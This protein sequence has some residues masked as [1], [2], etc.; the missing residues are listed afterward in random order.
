M[1][2]YHSLLLTVLLYL[3]YTVHAAVTGKNETKSAPLKCP[4]DKIPFKL[5]VSEICIPK[6]YTAP[7]E[8]WLRTLT[9]NLQRR[10]YYSVEKIE[11]DLKYLTI[12]HILFLIINVQ[13]SYFRKLPL[14]VGYLSPIIYSLLYIFK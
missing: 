14:R 13:I 1:K 8:R 10:N 12:S 2:L 9:S 4:E 3:L 11:S 6:N 5:G 7:A